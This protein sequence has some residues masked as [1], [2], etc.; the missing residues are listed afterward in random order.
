M[1]SFPVVILGVALG[2]ALALG[3]LKIGPI[4]ISGDSLAI[5]IFII[6]IVYVPYMARP[7]RGQVLSLREKEFVEAARVAG[8]GAAPDHVHGGAA[9]PVLDAARLLHAADRQRG[10]ARGGAVVPG[11]RSSAPERLVGHDDRRGHRPHLDGAAPD[12]RAG[13]DA[14]ADGPVAERASATASATRST[15]GPRCGSST[16]GPLHRPPAVP[17]GVRDVRRLGAHLPDLQR[18]PEQ[19]PGGAD[20]GPAGAASPRSRRSARSGASTRA[21]RSSTSPR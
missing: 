11:R 4:T 9:E 5:P 16:D 1:W 12:D 13:P 8:R 6:G 17:D 21:C 20:G 7:I 19:R 15:R 18:H 14:R 3:G 2:V 10:A